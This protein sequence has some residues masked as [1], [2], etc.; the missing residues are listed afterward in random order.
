[1]EGT[2]RVQVTFLIE[3]DD[4]EDRTGLTEETYVLVTDAV[5]S[6]GGEDPKFEKVEE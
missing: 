4:P 1:M 3:A 6:V 5:M 2:M